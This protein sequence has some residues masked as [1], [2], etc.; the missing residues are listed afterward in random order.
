[1]IISSHR[2]C[3][4]KKKCYQKE[5]PTQIFSCEICKIFKNTYFEEHPLNNAIL[6]EK[7][8][9]N[10]WSQSMTWSD[11]CVITNV[12]R[13]LKF[14]VTYAKLCKLVIKFKSFCQTTIEKSSQEI[15]FMIASLFFRVVP[16]IFHFLTKW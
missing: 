12:N 15:I 10:L 3:S 7:Y 2:R 6:S 16:A 8:T 5:T 1:M 4:V 11:S 13:N 14:A 9:V